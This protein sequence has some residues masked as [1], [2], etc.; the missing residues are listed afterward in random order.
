[1][2]NLVEFHIR[3]STFLP[4]TMGRHRFNNT[5]E[6]K[7]AAMAANSKVREVQILI[8]LSTKAHGNLTFGDILSTFLLR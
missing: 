4:V 1:V 6:Q 7:R 2:K 8:F 3:N 5:P